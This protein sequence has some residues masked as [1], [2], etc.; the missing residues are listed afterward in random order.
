MLKHEICQLFW[1]EKFVTLDATQIEKKAYV[2]P[3]HK[4]VEE[5][6]FLWWQKGHYRFFYSSMY[7]PETN[8]FT[9]ELSH[10]AGDYE[11]A[12]EMVDF[13][14]D[15]EPLNTMDVFAGKSNIHQNKISYCVLTR[16]FNVLFLFHRLRRFINW[17]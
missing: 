10:E 15:I 2:L 13:N 4:I 11:P 8:E 9:T 3:E 14:T 17:S 12:S 1:T 7:D 5:H 6:P 16:F